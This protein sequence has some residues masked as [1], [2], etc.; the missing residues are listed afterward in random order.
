[1]NELTLTCPHCDQKIKAEEYLAH[2]E[3]CSKALTVKHPSPLEEGVKTEGIETPIDWIGMSEM[4]VN[5]LNQINLNFQP[6]TEE[7]RRKIQRACESLMEASRS[8]LDLASSRV[9]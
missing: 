5:L 7:E 6:R 8:F 2:E 9:R 3:T 4:I 1:M